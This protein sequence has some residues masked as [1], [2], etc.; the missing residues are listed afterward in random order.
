[1]A[2]AT[3]AEAEERKVS[4]YDHEAEDGCDQEHGYDEQARE[5]PERGLEAAQAS[6]GISGDDR[7]GV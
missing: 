6:E 3:I 2:I 5:Y 1:V 4:E 7:L